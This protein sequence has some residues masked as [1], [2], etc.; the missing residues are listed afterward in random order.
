MGN[1][2]HFTVS[3]PSG[4]QQAG[5]RINPSQGKLFPTKDAGFPIDFVRLPLFAVQHPGS[6]K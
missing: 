3:T 2:L 6:S 1:W 5:K 4:N